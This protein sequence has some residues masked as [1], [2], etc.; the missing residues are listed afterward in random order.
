MTS[1]RLLAVGVALAIV[2]N[3]AGLIALAAG[4]RPLAFLFGGLAAL[5]PI[6]ILI[7]TRG[8]ITDVRFEDEEPAP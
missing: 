1:S 5:G 2:N 7:G 3:P 4:S 6:L 8:I